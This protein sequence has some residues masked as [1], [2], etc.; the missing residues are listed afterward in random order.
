MSKHTEIELNFGYGV[1]LGQVLVLAVGCLS[2]VEGDSSADNEQMTGDGGCVIS[3]CEAADACCPSVLA[4]ASDNEQSNYTAR[5]E[6]VQSL[7]VEGQVTATFAFT[8]MGQFGNV[9]LALNDEVDLQRVVFTGYVDGVVGSILTAAI[10]SSPGEACYYGAA[11]M[12]RPPNS[13]LARE[14]SS[15]ELDGNATCNG[16]AVKGRGSQIILGIQ[17]T[18][19]GEASVTIERVELVPRP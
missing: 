12:R 19:A 17:S 4:N 16:Q 10:G 9:V 3:G 6:I 1:R 13:V 8:D 15:F 11:V 7:L 18:A 2:C 5:P 14:P